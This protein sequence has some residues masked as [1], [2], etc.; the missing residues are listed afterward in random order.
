MSAANITGCLLV[1]GAVIFLL[2]TLVGG[3]DLGSKAQGC[4]AQL[5][6]LI[7]VLFWLVVI[8]GIGALGL[9]LALLPGN[10]F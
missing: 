7:A 5:G 6:C 4:T 9:H 8:G 10:A 1:I 2:K 3:A